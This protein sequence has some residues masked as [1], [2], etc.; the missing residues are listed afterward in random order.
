M[1][2]TSQIDRAILEA[3]LAE[4][5]RQ[6]EQIEAMMTE[7][8]RHLRGNTSSAA[9]RAATAGAPV[10]RTVSAAARKRM[11]AAQRKRWAAPKKTEQ[12]APQKRTMS[13][14]ARKRIGQATKRRWAAFRA[15]KAAA[16]KAA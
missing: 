3:A 15:N 11:A 16:A 7:I 4:Y 8:R 1:S 10:K 2:A 14:T 9:E 6:R 13:A 12:P 5:E